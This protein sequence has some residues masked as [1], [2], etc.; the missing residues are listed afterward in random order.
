LAPQINQ[1]ANNA[2]AQREHTL[3]TVDTKI[4]QRQIEI[5]HLN[6]LIDNRQ[7]GF[8][9]FLDICQKDFESQIQAVIDRETSN[10]DGSTLNNILKIEA[11]T[12]IEQMVKI[13][14]EIKA[15]I[16][17]HILSKKQDMYH[18]MDNLKKEIIERL[19]STP[20]PSR[21]DSN[22]QHDVPTTPITSAR[23]DAPDT[24]DASPRQP[25]NHTARIMRASNQ[26][27]SNIHH[28]K[29]E[30]I[31]YNLPADPRQDQLEHF[32]NALVTSLESNKMPIQLLNT[33]QPQGTTLPAESTVDATT[34]DTVNRILVNKLMKSI[35]DECTSLH[36]VLDSHASEQ[37]GYSA[38]YSIMRTKCRY[39]QD[40]H[41]RDPRG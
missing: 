10:T 20:E 41:H 24:D 18:R 16:K 22:T 28:F 17:D 3:G 35:P 23:H 31:H 13:R 33:Q 6:E 40:P 2:T 5:A 36:P 9:T 29:R 25:W 26:V 19:T 30:I 38:L 1:A 12:A 37:D 32:Y 7:Q 34:L 21:H 15:D 4:Q 11:T 14:D 39:L 8:I 27:M